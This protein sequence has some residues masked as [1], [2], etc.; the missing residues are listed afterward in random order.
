[1][2]GLA[3]N[4]TTGAITGTPTTAAVSSVTLTATNGT[5]TSPGASLTLTIAAAAVVPPPVVPVV[6]PAIQAV[7]PLL[8]AP[9]TNWSDYQPA[10]IKVQPVPGVNATFD[11]VYHQE[12]VFTVGV[13]RS[14]I[15]GESLVTVATGNRTDLIVTLMDNGLKE[16]D[17]RI[18]GDVVTTTTKVVVGLCATEEQVQAS[19]LGSSTTTTPGTVV[20]VLFFYDESTAAAADQLTVEAYGIAVIEN[21]NLVLQNSGVTNLRWRYTGAV[22]VAGY[23]STGNTQTDLTAMANSA[24]VLGAFVLQKSNE[25]IADQAMFIF[26]AFQTGG[27]SG[28]AERP[29]HNSTVYWQVPWFVYVHQLG[30]NFGCHHGRVFDAV[31]DSNGQ[32]SYGLA[33][34]KPLTITNTAGA[35]ST[36]QVGYGTIMTYWG[37]EFIQPYFSNPSVS[38]TY[39]GNRGTNQ[40]FIETRAIGVAA[41]QPKAADNARTIREAALPMAGYRVVA[42]N[43]VSPIP[44]VPPPVTPPV[45]PSQGGGGGGA[46][47]LWFLLALSG[48]AAFRRKF[49]RK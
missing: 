33:W 45:T 25:L 30:H 11:V 34:T 18:R 14:V 24:S 49:M 31:A 27:A 26:N 15:P 47:S 23:T 20:S 46:P 38:I 40:E 21:G 12:G 42:G 19:L 29:G 41:D 44:T 22:K 48:L 36:I 13:G 8:P 28:R 43:P 32:F 35:T 5:G 10:Q 9:V 6:P 2:A 16:Y 3:V 39:A 37:L 7:L 17:V 1:P 4:T